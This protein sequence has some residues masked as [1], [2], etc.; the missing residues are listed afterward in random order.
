MS[1]T[2][3][4]G[5]QVFASLPI[6]YQGTHQQKA[7]SEV[8]EL[9]HKPGT[10]IWDVGEPKLWLTCYNSKRTLLCGSEGAVPSLCL[11][12]PH[13][14]G[15][16]VSLM[17]KCWDEERAK[18]CQ[19]FSTWT[20]LWIFSTADP[21]DPSLFAKMCLATCFSHLCGHA[22]LQWDFVSCCRQ[23]L[24]S[25]LESG[26]TASRADQEKVAQLTLVASKLS[27]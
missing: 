3:V 26:L 2:W 12:G 11:W 4:S 24:F 23:S 19:C 18:F 6:A 9:G 1:F 22:H 21:T 13:S 15:L 16:L 17:V 7:G 5:T 20:L 14:S 25:S 27:S 8:G 10:L